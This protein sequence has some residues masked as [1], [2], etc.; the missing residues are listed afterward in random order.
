[1]EWV[2]PYRL[3]S[4]CKGI[5]EQ[6]SGISKSGRGHNT[7]DLWAWQLFRMGVFA[8]ER[9]V[10]VV[11]QWIGRGLFA[12]WISFQGNS[13]C[14]RT[15]TSEKTFQKNEKWNKC[16]DESYILLK[17]RLTSYMQIF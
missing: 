15:Y 7:E 13:T 5:E 6:P 11:V 3:T 9:P 12:G 2:S 1:M 14:M 4:N 17:L 8:T 10:S 16:R